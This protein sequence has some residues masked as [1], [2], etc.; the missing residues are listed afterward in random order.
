KP[1]SKAPSR[2]PNP[3]P[4]VAE[5]LLLPPQKSYTPPSPTAPHSP[6]FPSSSLSLLIYY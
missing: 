2:N 6:P 1:W 4:A 3:N 5:A